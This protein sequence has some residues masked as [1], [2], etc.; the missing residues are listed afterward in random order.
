MSVINEKINDELHPDDEDIMGLSVLFGS[1]GT[2]IADRV[3]DNRL[4]VDN[5]FLWSV[6][7][8]KDFDGNYRKVSVGVF[9]HIFT[10][11]KEDL[12]KAL[13]DAF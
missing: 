5:R 6:G 9:G 7:R 8:F 11:N 3:V 1:I 4:S 12:D 2:G 13:E 10:F